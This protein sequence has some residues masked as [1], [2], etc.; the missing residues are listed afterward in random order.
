MHLIPLVKFFIFNIDSY[1][2]FKNMDSPF[3]KKPKPTFEW[4]MEKK[5]MN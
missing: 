2:R 1:Y 4:S 5:I 3:L